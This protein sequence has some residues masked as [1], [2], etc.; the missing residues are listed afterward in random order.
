MGQAKAFCYVLARLYPEPTMMEVGV[1]ADQPILRAK[2]DDWRDREADLN[3]LREMAARHTAMSDL[4]A[5]LL[6]EPPEA[7]PGEDIK[8]ARLTL[9]TVGP[10]RPKC[11]K[12]NEPRSWVRHSGG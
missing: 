12:R 3:T 7:P 5:D 2:F 9:S 1:F 6:I 4:L 8:S 11:V 10:D